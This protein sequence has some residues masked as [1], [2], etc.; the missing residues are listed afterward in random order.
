MTIQECYHA[1]EGDYA[2]VLSRLYREELVKK[3]TAMFLSDK[4]FKIL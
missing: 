4:S 3:F 1:L 2:E